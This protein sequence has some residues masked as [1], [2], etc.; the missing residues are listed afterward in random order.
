MRHFVFL[1]IHLLPYL[2]H[3][4]KILNAYQIVCILACSPSQV[5]R[6]D[7]KNWVLAHSILMALAFVLLLPTG[8]LVA[9]HRWECITE[10]SA[11][12]IVHIDDTGLRAPPT[13][14]S[15][16]YCQAQVGVS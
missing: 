8:V 2:I 16:H 14:W 3:H 7:L 15:A 11:T 13:D 4:H 10:L 9:R 12:Y 6:S 5:V 1:A